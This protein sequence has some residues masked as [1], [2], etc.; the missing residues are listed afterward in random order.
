MI[1]AEKETNKLCDTAAL[2]KIVD[3]C[4]LLSANARSKMISLAECVEEDI[5]WGG[6]LSSVEILV[7]LYHAVL[8]VKRESEFK[9]R[10]KF[11]LSKGHAAI[12]LYTIMNL[13]GMISDALYRTYRQDGA[14]LSELLHYDKELGFEVSGGSLGLGIS[15]GV[16]LA[17]LARKKGYTYHTY[18]EVGDGELDEGNIW[19]AAMSASQ[20]GLDNLTVIVD[21]NVLQS[22][23]CTEDI[24]DLGNIGDKFSS[25]GFEVHETDGHDCRELLNVFTMKSRNNKPKVIIA[26]TVKGKGI[27]FM[28]GNYLWHDKRLQGKELMAAKEELRTDA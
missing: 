5:H 23:G 9:I 1:K 15:Y 25:F 27:S 20:F 18:V 6:A 26:H 2:D 19:E 4:V 7:T 13:E 8:N 22:D 28:E 16:G 17:L 14:S 11:L 12:A 10:D 3:E 21:A 24:M